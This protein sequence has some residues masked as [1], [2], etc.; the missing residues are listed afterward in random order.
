MIALPAFI[1]RESWEGF[2]EMRRLIKKPLTPR[3]EKLI[4]RDLWNLK[5]QGHDPNECLDRSAINN[6]LGVWAPKAE[7]SGWLP[8]YKPEP[9]EVTK[10]PDWV[11]QKHGLRSVPK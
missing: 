10:A 6:W 2:V 8:E 5:T 1:D 3:G 4:L 9:A 11:K 7:K